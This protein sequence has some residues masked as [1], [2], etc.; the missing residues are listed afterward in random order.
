MPHRK[1]ILFTAL[2]AIALTAVV[3]ADIVILKSGRVIPDVKVTEDGA[4]YYLEGKDQSYFINREAVESIARTQKPG[5]ARTLPEK[6]MAYARSIPGRAAR[7]YRDYFAVAA[8]AGILLLLLIALLVFKFIW[9][10]MK[11]VIKA[12][13]RRAGIVSAARHLDADE[14]AVMREFFLQQSNSIELPVSDTAVAGLIEKGVLIPTREKGEYSACG[15]MLPVIISP[16]AR[17]HI[18]AGK[19]G[20]PSSMKNEKK[21][22]A[23]LTSR[24]EF[25]YEL[26]RFYKTLDQKPR[27]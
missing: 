22:E 3:H 21:R 27:W 17:R 7:F 2:F 16:A 4:A 5:A 26:A 1:I 24:P 23:V 10:N 11:P 14:K 20:M 9:I 19:I 8:A 25:I 6:A 12:N 13:F 15:L 18:K